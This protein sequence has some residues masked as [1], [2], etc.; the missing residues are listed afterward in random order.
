[1]FYRLWSTATQAFCTIQKKSHALPH[2]TRGCVLQLARV[3]LTRAAEFFQV[4]GLF[5]VENC[6]STNSGI[7]IALLHMA[8]LNSLVHSLNDCAQS[9]ASLV[10]ANHVKLSAH[11]R[12]TAI[13]RAA[14]VLYG[15]RKHGILGK[16]SDSFELFYPPRSTCD[17]SEA[18]RGWEK[19]RM[20]SVALLS[21][22]SD[23]AKDDEGDMY[24]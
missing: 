3:K 15:R 16:P 12:R 14:L 9:N 13:T 19:S 20:S 8:Q 5:R 10:E 4:H 2:T 22:L 23:T 1:M 6:E 17:V 11:C 21:Y 18:S 7:T 24:T